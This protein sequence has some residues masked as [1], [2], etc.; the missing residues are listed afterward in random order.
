MKSQLWPLKVTAMVVFIGL[1]TVGPRPCAAGPIVEFDF[2]PASSG[3]F[4]SPTGVLFLDS[5]TLIC[6][7]GSTFKPSW[8]IFG[9]SS[10]IVDNLVSPTISGWVLD[11]PYALKMESFDLVVQQWSVAYEQFPGWNYLDGGQ[12][13]WMRSS[14]IYMPDAVPTAAMLI[15]SVTG[16]GAVVRRFNLGTRL[17]SA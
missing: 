5:T 10:A 15:V 3:S 1:L 9:L 13:R 2:V 8:G 17:K 4:G 11:Y 16:M 12:G 6:Q 7:P 14:T